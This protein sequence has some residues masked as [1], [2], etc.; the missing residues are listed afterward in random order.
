MNCKNA[1]MRKFQFMG[2]QNE[3]LKNEMECQMRKMHSSELENEKLKEDL[4]YQ[5]KELEQQAKVLK[6]Q[7]A[8]NDI[9]RKN[10]LAEMEKVSMLP[11]FFPCI[12][13]Y[14]EMLIFCNYS[15]RKW[16]VRWF[17]SDHAYVIFKLSLSLSLS[18]KAM[19]GSS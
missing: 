5:Q 17:R 4:F 11:P 14:I 3:K 13:T 8:Q 15:S 12:H 19:F 7:E 6:E 9:D 10:F 1:E 16:Q 18:V 2:L